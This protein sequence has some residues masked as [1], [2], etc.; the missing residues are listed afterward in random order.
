MA[1]RWAA[2]AM[3]AGHPNE[4]SPL[5][6]RNVPFAIQVG[7]KDSAYDRNKVAAEWGAK[8]DALEKDDPAGYK[9]FAE[10]HAGKGHWMEMLDRKAIPWMEKFTRNP[11][12]DR[13]VWHQDDVLHPTFYWL[14]IPSDSGKAGQEISASRSG[15]TITLSWKDVPHVLVRLSDDMLD[16]DQPVTVRI[17]EKEVFSA[18]TERTIGTLVRTLSERG[19]FELMFSAEIPVRF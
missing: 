5:G 2:A 13:V 7:E 16:L 11:R 19:D 6:L 1:D 18:R 14:A 17:G 12:P 9:H 3:M 4:A 10:L 15:Q 8:L